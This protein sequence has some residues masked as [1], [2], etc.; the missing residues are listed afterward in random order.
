MPRQRRIKLSNLEYIVNINNDVL[1]TEVNNTKTIERYR[2]ST[3]FI[4]IKWNS[5]SP[6]FVIIHY[7]YRYK[8]IIILDLRFEQKSFKIFR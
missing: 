5:E 2:G 7:R 8:L 4:N 3:K 6:T 1:Q